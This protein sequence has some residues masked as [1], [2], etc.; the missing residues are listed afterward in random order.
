MSP[1]YLYAIEK[2]F[3][4]CQNNSYSRL[5]NVSLKHM[6]HKF[7]GL[8]LVFMLLLSGHLY[9]QRST[10]PAALF[11]EPRTYIAYRVADSISIDGRPDDQ[12]WKNAHW[13][14]S[15]IDIEGA[16]K[17]LPTWNTRMKMLWDDHYL[18]LL[19]ELEEPHVWGTLTK[20]DQVVYYDN[21]FELFID[22]DGD[23]HHYYEIEINALNT[24]F[25]LFLPRPYRNLG[26]ANIGWHAE[27]LRSAIHV[28][29]TLND[30]FDTDTA[31]YVEM[32][33]PFR[34]LDTAQNGKSPQPDDIWNI[35][36]SRVQ[37]AIEDPAE[38]YRKKINPATQKPFPEDNWVWS[39][40]GVINM[41]Y[42]ER[43]G[44]VKF[45]AQ[46]GGDRREFELPHYYWLKKELFT[47]YYLQKNYF[48]SHKRYAN[49]LADLGLNAAYTDHV[50]GAATL[51]LDGD[52]RRFT[53][54]LSLQSGTRWQID[55][56]GKITNLNA[57]P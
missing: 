11:T 40:Q 43:W 46:V 41:H 48:R 29:G 54:T 9:A 45:S 2:L 14:E 20:H 39:P 19:A 1:L 37:W 16:E 52:S 3:R 47:V 6:Y 44:F 13:S 25:D 53:A 5:P 34:S 57:I 38:G 12:A 51:K 56:Q 49:T 32:A 28:M 27:G 35:N 10:L 50:N 33:I 30:P 21:D 22:P 31:W 42:P 18:Y 17:P 36:F 23:T 4:S 55:E 8:V 24:I 15:F 26:R 7:Q